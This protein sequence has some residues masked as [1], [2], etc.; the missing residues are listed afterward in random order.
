MYL[1]TYVLLSNSGL[2]I[3]TKEQIMFFYREKSSVEVSPK[4]VKKSLRRG[5]ASRNTYPPINR[6]NFPRNSRPCGLY[7]GYRGKDNID[8]LEEQIF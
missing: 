5:K 4:K 6:N 2:D 3:R 7:F 8:F 1:C